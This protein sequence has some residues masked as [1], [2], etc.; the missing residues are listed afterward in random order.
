MTSWDNTPVT[1]LQARPYVREDAPSPAGP[2]PVAFVSWG[3]VAGRAAEIADALGGESRC[4]FPKGTARRPSVL[5]RYLLSAAGTA[6]Y[7]WRKRPGVVVVTNPP[8]PAAWFTSLCARALGASVILDSHPGGFGAQGDRVSARLQWVHRRLVRRAAGV[9]VSDEAWGERVRVWGGQPVVVHEAPTGCGA[10]APSPG[11]RLRLLVVGNFHRDEPIAEVLEAARRLPDCDFLVTGEPSRCPAELRASVPSNARLVGFL[12]P[13]G[14]QFALA[15]CDA[16]VTLT[17]EPTSVMRAA[18][19]AVYARRPVIMSDWPVARRLFPHALHASND[20]SALAAAIAVLQSDYR[21]FAGRVD[22]ARNEQLERWEEQ[23]RGLVDVVDAALRRHAPP[24]R[25]PRSAASTRSTASAAIVLDDLDGQTTV[26]RIVTAAARGRGGRM[27][28]V[29]VDTLRLALADNALRQLINECDLVLA[30]GVPIVWASRLQG[31]PVAERVAASEMIWPTCEVA[32]R[33][34]VGVFLLGGAP[35]TAARAAARLR[36]QFPGLQIEHQCPPFGFEH[37]QSEMDAILSKLEEVRPG[38]VFCGFGSPKQERLMAVLVRRFPSMWF[39]ACGGTFAMLCGDLPPA[40]GWMRR[41]SLEWA[42]RLRLEPRRLFGRY[43]LRD[44][45]FAPK[46]LASSAASRLG[47]PRRRGG[48]LRVRHAS[49]TVALTALPSGARPLGARTGARREALHL[50]H[51]DGTDDLVVLL[52]R[53][54]Q[55]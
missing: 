12:D 35:S 54:E 36:A 51:P 52:Q 50:A 39:V 21:R 31:T 14:Y 48:L 53:K 20:A 38:I 22:A 41:C 42:H 8:V 47:G 24:T 27:A 33:H 9:I 32:A 23:L 11:P 25:S 37:E 16:V 49:A 46:L 1:T 29:N 34:G 40:P 7:L 17:T 6:S 19:E 45:P 3:A 5:L 26:R 28:N 15:A 2:R 18:Y 30:D 13:D 44:L 4:F 43:V 55:R 10:P